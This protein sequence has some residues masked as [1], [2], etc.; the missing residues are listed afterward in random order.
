MTSSFA[1][2]TDGLSGKTLLGIGFCLPWQKLIHE[3][4]NMS[5]TKTR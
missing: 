4:E 3:V 1:W 5:V 2:V